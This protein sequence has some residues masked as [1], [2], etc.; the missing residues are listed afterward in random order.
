M[1]SPAQPTPPGSGNGL[2][3]AAQAVPAA[4][5]PVL[6]A[7]PLTAPESVDMANAVLLPG[8]AMGG[9]AGLRLASQRVPAFNAALTAA[10]SDSYRGLLAATKA[11]TAAARQ[12]AGRGAAAASR[13][14][15]SAAAKAAP[16]VAARA[17]MLTLSRVAMAPIPVVGEVVLAA[18]WLFDKDSRSLVN[19]L[20]SCVGGVGFPPDGDAPPSPPRTQ[21]LPLTHDGNRDPDIEKIDQGMSKTNASAFNY[22][23]DDVWPSQPTV[24]TTPDF[25]GTVT[26]VNKLGPKA[27]N[28]ADAIRNVSNSLTGASTGQFATSLPGKLG[29]IADSLDKYQSSVAPGVA[30]AV[31]GVT[32][33]AN[34][35]Y[36]KF[37]EVNN[38]NRKEIANST[39]GL[40]PFTANHVNAAA[41]DDAIS[42]AKSTADEIS[43]HNAGVSGAFSNWSVPPASASGLGS[44]TPVS[45]VTPKPAP[46]A[47]VAAA[48]AP[49]TAPSTPLAQTPAESTKS[50]LDGLLSSLPN[51]VPSMPA[52]SMPGGGLPMPSMPQAGPESGLNPMADQQPLDDHKDKDDK[53]KPQDDAT[54]KDDTGHKPEDP[55]IK[56]DPNTPGGPAVVHGAPAPHPA[57][58]P[59][60]PGADKTVRIGNKDYTFDSPRIAAAIKESIQAAQSGPGIP[61]TQTLADNGFTVP[62][63][64]QPLGQSVDGI[65]AAKPGAVIVSNNG[66]DMAWYLGEGQAV[67]EQGEVK[68]VDQVINPA[69]GNDGIYQM[70]EPGT[71]VV[72]VTASPLGQ[73]GLTTSQP[74]VGTADIPPTP[75][76]DPAQATP[77]PT[78]NPN[79]AAQPLPHPQGL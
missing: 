40:I 62:P 51:A 79:T 74:A 64:G 6:T 20:I 7:R 13:A 11:P 19:G 2:A 48:P 30:A 26:A 44:T 52:P 61:I 42:S 17:G 25:K 57:A 21:F 9:Y 23:P 4:T 8:A 56:D 49:S 46:A 50:P 54:Q 73:D 71:P 69:G 75:A 78:A 24:E 22:R 68:P 53:D 77:A 29:P 34:D 45:A 47:P 70:P 18:T 12:A 59:P 37:R 28:I 31:N 5:S 65:T 55:G 36:Q 41:M 1:T 60:P 16:R 39:S 67:T 38:G 3:A 35:L 14:V 43:K 10:R 63:V 58:V 32:T 72:D 33:N 66:A 15:A 27:S 76:T